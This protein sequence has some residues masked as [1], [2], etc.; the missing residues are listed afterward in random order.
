[1][2]TID[3]ILELHGGKGKGREQFKGVNEKNFVFF[4]ALWLNKEI[5][6]ILYLTTIFISY[7]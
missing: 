5:L 1:M 7:T 6:F 4:F 3:K 2:S